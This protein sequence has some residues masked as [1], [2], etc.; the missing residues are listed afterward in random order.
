[1][2]LVVC[3]IYEFPQGV[4]NVFQGVPV[5]TVNWQIWETNPYRDSF[6]NIYCRIKVRGPFVQVET[7]R[8]HEIRAILEDQIFVFFGGEFEEEKPSPQKV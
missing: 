3:P 1:L 2:I 8:A 5:P 7:L 4:A 6:G